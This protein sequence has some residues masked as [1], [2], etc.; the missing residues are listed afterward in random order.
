MNQL[1]SISEK[2]N[3]LWTLSQQE[4]IFLEDFELKFKEDLQT[5]ITGETLFLKD[6]K[7][8]IGKNLYKKWLQ[9]LQSKGF[10]YEIDFK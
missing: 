9:K 7:V 1:A 10:D 5:F 2:L 3:A 8:V 6:G 4:S